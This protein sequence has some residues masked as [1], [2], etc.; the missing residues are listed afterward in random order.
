MT[1]GASLALYDDIERWNGG[2]KE[3]PDRGAMYITVID[4]RW[5]TIRPLQQ[6]KA[7]IPLIIK[8]FWK[9]TLVLWLLKIWTE[10]HLL[11]WLTTWMSQASTGDFDPFGTHGCS[12][13]VFMNSNI[14]IRIISIWKTFQLKDIFWNKLDYDHLISTL[15]SCRVHL[16]ER[17][18]TPVFWPREFHGLYS[19]WGHRES[20]KTERLSL[21]NFIFF[22]GLIFLSCYQV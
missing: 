13:S 8:D 4:S 19:P 3:A 10:F 5:C 21:S 14:F 15:T 2:G 1:Q 17:L 16:R 20:D 7:V 22:C 18:P 12:D 9:K 6:C 11:P